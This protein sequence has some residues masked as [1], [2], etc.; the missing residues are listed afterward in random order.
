MLIAPLRNRT[1]IRC[2]ARCRLQCIISTFARLC[3]S[4]GSIQRARI[5]SQLKISDDGDAEL[6]YRYVEAVS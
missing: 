5:A 1:R 3:A 6:K 2:A 4:V